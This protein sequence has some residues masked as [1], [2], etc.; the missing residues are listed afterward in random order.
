MVQDKNARGD[1]A[2]QPTGVL[3]TWLE[4]S[5]RDDLRPWF[6]QMHALIQGAP[7]TASLAS[8]RLLQHLQ[9]LRA[10]M[11]LFDP[12]AVP[13]RTVVA[14]VRDLLDRGRDARRLGD[15]EEIQD[16]FA[17][18]HAAVRAAGEA[19]VQNAS[20][21]RRVALHLDM[22]VEPMTRRVAWCDAVLEEM[23][24]K[25]VQRRPDAD[26]GSRQ[27]LLHLGKCLRS[28][29]KRLQP[30]QDVLTDIQ[31]LHSVA[32]GCLARRGAVLAILH[33]ELP[34]HR[35]RWSTALSKAQAGSADRQAGDAHAQDAASAT[36]QARTFLALQAR[37]F[38]QVRL[39]EEA[40]A[41]ALNQL[42]AR[43]TSVLH[44]PEWQE[45]PTSPTSLFAAASQPAALADPP[46]AASP[47]A[48]QPAAPAARQPRRI[49]IA[50]A[51]AVARRN[52]RACPKFASWVALHDVLMQAAVRGPG[53]PPPGPVAREDWAHVSPLN[54]RLRLREQINW[55][56][57]AGCLDRVVALLASLDEDQW[58]H[59]Q[60]D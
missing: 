58:E 34:D 28:F 45:T 48:A 2:H 36:E 60:D 41:E 35:Q 19:H 6:L 11:E 37:S 7:D 52:N 44:A 55:A 46:T 38:L 3:A 39:D 22:D 57:G 29:R 51:M 15:V 9:R 1:P 23:R 14:R 32:Q 5:L 8:A 17:H 18:A 50:D 26:G 10:R 31:E 56:Q 42:D 21:L 53:P 13:S 4:A 49:G 59:M 33:T 30:L 20:G 16:L 54:K 27:L 12:P 25:L 47:G 40:L 43:L 24:R